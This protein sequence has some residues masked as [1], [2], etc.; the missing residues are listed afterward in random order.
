MRRGRGAVTS[1]A[2]RGDDGASSTL[3]GNGWQ[4]KSLFALFWSVV[5]S[6]ILAGKTLLSKAVLKLPW[7][8]VYHAVCNGNIPGNL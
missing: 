3:H 6:M 5:L 7:E 1:A 8:Y 4:S 2:A